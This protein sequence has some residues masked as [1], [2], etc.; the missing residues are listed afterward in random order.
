M[1]V[2]LFITDLL[3]FIFVTICTLMF[4]K[5]IPFNMEKYLLHLPPDEGQSDPNNVSLPLNIIDDEGQSDTNV[6]TL[7]LNIIN[8]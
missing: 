1:I 7:P 6:V 4:F 5:N 3:H 8:V 2:L